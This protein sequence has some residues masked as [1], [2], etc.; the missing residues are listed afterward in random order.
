VVGALPIS[1]GLTQKLCNDN[2]IG[3]LRFG[4]H[5]VIQMALAAET[6]HLML[7]SS[8]LTA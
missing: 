7:S 5:A 8:P 2:K 3:G 1:I 6:L 4:L